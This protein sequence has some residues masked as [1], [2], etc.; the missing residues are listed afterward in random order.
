MKTL[1]SCSFEG[2]VCYIL[3]LR[4]KRCVRC[5]WRTSRSTLFYYFYGCFISVQLC[6]FVLFKF[7]YGIL[8]SYAQYYVWFLI[9]YFFISC[10]MY[11]SWS[12]Y[13]FFKSL[14]SRWVINIFF[15]HKIILNSLLYVFI[16]LRL[17]GKR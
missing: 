14:G 7:G 6:L 8:Y 1:H 12:L 9:E 2:S 17:F 13:N 3:I 11:K 4:L 16:F 10:Q 15:I 5:I